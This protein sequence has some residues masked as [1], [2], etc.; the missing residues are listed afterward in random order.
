MSEKKIINKAF[1]IRLLRNS[2]IGKTAVLI[3]LSALCACPVLFG[4]NTYQQKIFIAA[5]GGIIFVFVLAWLI[6]GY[7]KLKTL[8]KNDSFKLVS[9]ILKSTSGIGDSDALTHMCFYCG[10]RYGLQN[11]E[12]PYKVAKKS[13]VGERY[14][15]L[16]FE[17]LKTKTVKIVFNCNEYMVSHEIKWLCSYVSDSEFETFKTIPVKSVALPHT[18][19]PKN[20]KEEKIKSDCEYNSRSDYKL[21]KN[22]VLKVF[23]IVRKI[24]LWIFVLVNFCFV[25]GGI[26]NI[27][28]NKDIVVTC[29]FS[30]FLFVAVL[31]LC[32]KLR[33]LWLLYPAVFFAG[34]AFFT[35]PGKDIGDGN[36]GCGIIAFIFVIIVVVVNTIFKRKN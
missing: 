3:L 5:I 32:T 27:S 24:L 1:L 23:N 4:E 19:Q 34:A 10:S 11:I 30:A 26:F 29:M 33:H 14:Y 18:A 36:V 35:E 22:K 7:F 21:V 9:G 31:M 17:N 6:L 13:V 25:F 8:V 12:V 20:N 15:I 2:C 16:W 28:S